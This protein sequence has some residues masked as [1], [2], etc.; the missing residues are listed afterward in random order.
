MYCMQVTH[1]YPKDYDLRGLESLQINVV[2][3]GKTGS[4]KSSTGNTLLGHSQFQVAKGWRSCTKT[5][6]V[7]RYNHKPIM[8]DIVDTPGLH[9]PKKKELNNEETLREIA[10]TVLQFPEGVHVFLVVCR[11]DVRFTN[12]EI[13]TIEDIVEKFGER[14]YDFSILVFT[15]GENLIRCGDSLRDLFTSGEID[16]DYI[17]NL[18]EKVRDR[19]LAVENIDCLETFRRLQH[20][21]LQCAICEVVIGNNMKTYTNELFEMVEECKKQQEHLMNVIPTFLSEIFKSSSEQ[22]LKFMKEKLKIKDFQM[23]DL[24]CQLNKFD[25]MGTF[26]RSHVENEVK[27][28]IK[29][30]ALMIEE[31]IKL[32]AVSR[33]RERRREEEAQRNAEKDKQ[34]QRAKKQ[35]RQKFMVHLERLSIDQ[36]QSMIND[37]DLNVP[38]L[39]ETLENTGDF[40]GAIDLHAVVQSV[41]NED[42]D[43]IQRE[44]DRRSHDKRQAKLKSMETIFR[45]KVNDHLSNLSVGELK[46]LKSNKE[47]LDIECLIT[48]IGHADSVDE[49]RKIVPQILN[50][51]YS[52]V[53]DFFVKDKEEKLARELF[54]TNLQGILNTKIK[55]ANLQDLEEFKKGNY[56]SLEQLNINW[57]QTDLNEDQINTYINQH[58]GKQRELIEGLYRVSK[59]NERN[60]KI[61]DFKGNMRP[62]L[63]VYIKD[64]LS[65][66]E[67]SDLERL[68]KDVNNNLTD[69]E[70][71]KVLEAKIKEKMKEDLK[72]DEL[73]DK[74]I[75]EFIL[76]GIE[77]YIKILDTVTKNCK[78]KC[79]PGKAMITT[80]SSG[81]IPVSSVRIGDKV[82]TSSSEGTKTF[83]DV[84][85]IP[86]ADSND[87]VTYVS[88][89]T[90]SKAT[91][92]LSPNHYLYEG[93]LKNHKRAD[94]IKVGDMLF[95][96]QDGM[97]LPDRVTAVKQSIFKGAYCPYTLNGKVIVDCIAV[98]CF[99]TTFSPLVSQRL[100]AP[101]RVLYSVMPLPMYKSIFKT[102]NIVYVL[103]LSRRIKLLISNLLRL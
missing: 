19:A 94:E 64:Y 38:V 72:D 82:L 2:L 66:K 100:L 73:S 3:V 59:I 48:D 11:T 86:H 84:Y 70:F 80:K 32:I 53:V 65:S 69:N 35:I 6:E 51:V 50:D 103:N 54:F 101:L 75:K 20:I 62:E 71:Y 74:E 45:F 12:E 21:K 4:G 55:N 33:E 90:N 95:T 26:E 47:T 8:M 83:Q 96:L 81:I 30:Q 17:Q 92:N 97:C 22:D 61:S 40:E 41:I 57:A 44:I 87:L 29:S 39:L 18:I 98:S 15:H 46:R 9:D 42:R 76:S 14:I 24:I 68:R 77:S 91:I 23:N 67:K 13:Q 43:I 102:S 37:P 52:T 78:K 7:A 31:C 5:I 85:L 27:K 49:F 60:K 1:D 56:I 36:L 89:T 93:S 10:K 28:E 25:V 16:R 34:E 58:F 63:E 99:T 88:I 79:F